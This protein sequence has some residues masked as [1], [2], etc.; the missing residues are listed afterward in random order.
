MRV[1][2]RLPTAT[3]ASTRNLHLEN[4]GQSKQ[5]WLEEF[6]ELPHGIPSDDT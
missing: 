6:L 5:E 4:Y 1:A 3:I 2:D